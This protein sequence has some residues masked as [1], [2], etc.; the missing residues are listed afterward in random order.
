M[1]QAP[2]AIPSAQSARSGAPTARSSLRKGDR[3]GGVQAR[4]YALPTR[5]EAVT[6]DAVI[7]GIESVCHMDASILLDPGST[8]LHVSSYFTRYFD[9]PP[10]SLVSPIHVS[11]LVGNSIIVDRVYRSCVE[12][13]GGLKTRVDLLLLSMVDFDVIL[14]MHWMS[15]CHIILDCHA[16]NVLLAMLLLPR[17][18][19]RGF[20]D[21]IPSRVISYVRT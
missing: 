18:E 8:Y 4:C 13:I 16:K 12:T 21:Y 6:S 19:W 7:T 15:P 10:E 1:T 20:L 2:A 11:T 3:S 17:I 14:G 5:P 9:M